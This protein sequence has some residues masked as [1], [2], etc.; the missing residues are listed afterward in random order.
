LASE[1]ERIAFGGRADL[2]RRWRPMASVG[3]FFFSANYFSSFSFIP[4]TPTP[5]V[6]VRAHDMYMPVE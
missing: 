3:P 2:G 6:G 4:V 5:I 1:P